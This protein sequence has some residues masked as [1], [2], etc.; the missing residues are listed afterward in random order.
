MRHPFTEPADYDLHRMAAHVTAATGTSVRLT[1]ER[2]DDGT[3]YLVP[4]DPGSGDPITVQAAALDEALAA[5][6]GHV[7]PDDDLAASI[8]A[9]DTSKITDTATRAALDALKAALVG[10]GRDSAVAG[11]PAR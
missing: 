9:V 10:K 1:A 4:V 7:P 11:R 6:A 8:N 5:E 3:T 2:D